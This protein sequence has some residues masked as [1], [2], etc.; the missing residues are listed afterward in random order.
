M[1]LRT[2]LAGALV[3]WLA[4]IGIQAQTVTP[5]PGFTAT[6]CNGYLEGSQSCNFH[7]SA[8]VNTFAD[9]AG[10]TAGANIDTNVS[11]SLT[12][13]A[14]VYYFVQLYSGS[15]VFNTATVPINVGAAGVTSVGGGGSA[16][17]N[18]FNHNFASADVRAFGDT[19]SACAG[20]G[21]FA[22]A[23]TSFSSAVTIDVR[24]GSSGSGIDANIWRLEVNARAETNSSYLNS[25]AHAWADPVISIE[26]GYAAAHP[27]VSLFFSPNLPVPEPSA[28]ALMLAGLALLAT[29]V[30]RRRGA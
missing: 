27:E 15:G 20:F 17:G 9:L 23:P 19:F 11:T 22:G 30:R 14:H 28:P 21:C 24:P 3:L 6:P 5:P 16:T 10:L 8:T 7:G 18:P 25:F 4:G 29:W 1:T 13:Y 26:P 12:T 2:R